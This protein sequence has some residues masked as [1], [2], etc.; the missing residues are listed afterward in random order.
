MKPTHKD[1][2]TLQLSFKKCHHQQCPLV[3]YLLNLHTLFSQQSKQIIFL[4]KIHL[5]LFS[6]IYSPGAHPVPDIRVRP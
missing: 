1:A 5:F 6:A 2:L 3:S 4:W